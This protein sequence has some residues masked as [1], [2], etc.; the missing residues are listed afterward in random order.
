MSSDEVRLIEQVKR[1]LELGSIIDDAKAEQEMI[2][3]QVRQLGLGKHT[4]GAGPIAVSPNRTWNAAQAEQV[5]RE[6]NPDLIAACSETVLTSAKAKAV[7]PPAV[8]ERCMKVNPAYKVQI[9]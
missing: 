5:L 6:I 3:A 8:Y 4:T 2:K 7:L 1:F 9:G